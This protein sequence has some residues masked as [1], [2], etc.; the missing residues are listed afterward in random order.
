MHVNDTCATFHL[1]KVIEDVGV[2]LTNHTTTLRS[3]KVKAK[4]LYCTS[5]VAL[6]GAYL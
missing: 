4:I 5:V 2:L 6:D 3:R 1:E